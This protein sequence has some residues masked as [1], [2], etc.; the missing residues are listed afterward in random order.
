MQ[1]VVTNIGKQHHISHVV[2]ILNLWVDTQVFIISE[3]TSVNSCLFAVLPLAA[4]L[5]TVD[6]IC[7]FDLEA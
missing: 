7:T 5:L 4:L 6:H 1:E 3:V 2:L